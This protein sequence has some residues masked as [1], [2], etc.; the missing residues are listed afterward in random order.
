M[1]SKVIYFMYL[2]KIQIQK[3]I[4][5]HTMKGG[6]NM[7]TIN[8]RVKEVRK[9][10]HLSQEE[11]GNRLGLSKSGI[12]NIEKG[13]RNVTSK[14]VK[15]ISTIFGIDE[16]WLTTGIHS[17]A[18]LLDKEKEIFASE[19]FLTYLKSFGYSIQIEQTDE[20]TFSVSIS[21]GKSTFI[22]TGAEFDDFQKNIERFISFELS[23]KEL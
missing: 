13:T 5:Q 8:E 23:K 4:L 6:E 10:L 22:F 21:N 20:E 7:E 19:S 11:F 9:N 2:P 14:H 3:C 1:F 15:L 18:N 12:S 17:N 16:Q